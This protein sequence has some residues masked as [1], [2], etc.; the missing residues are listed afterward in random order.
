[1]LSQDDLDKIEALIRKHDDGCFVII[2]LVIILI[3]GCS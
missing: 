1:M 2:L 3:Q